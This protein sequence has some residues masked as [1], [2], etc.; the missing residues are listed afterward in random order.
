MF[1]ASSCA[2]IS[3]IIEI[4]SLTMLSAVCSADDVPQITNMN[5]NKKLE[6]KKFFMKKYPFLKFIKLYRQCRHK[7]LSHMK[8]QQI[9][10]DAL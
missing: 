2:E 5:I 9:W 10:T 7:I 6:A 8:T 1:A 4:A 3:L